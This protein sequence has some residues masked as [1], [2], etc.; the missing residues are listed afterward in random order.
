MDQRPPGGHPAL[1][2]HTWLWKEGGT[3]R[4]R[5]PVEAGVAPLRYHWRDPE[6]SMPLGVDMTGSFRTHIQTLP[7]DA[8][9]R[10]WPG[11]HVRSRC[12]VDPRL[13]ALLADLDYALISLGAFIRSLQ[14]E[15]SALYGD[16]F[17]RLARAWILWKAAYLARDTQGPLHI[18]CYVA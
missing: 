14:A 3:T 17:S 2:A 12:R 6:Q 13:P 9:R 4:F 7:T 10:N 1:P 11:P 18:I 5:E 15:G 8:R 16:C